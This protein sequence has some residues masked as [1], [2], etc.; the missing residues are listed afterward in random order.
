MTQPAFLATGQ[1][2][3]PLYQAV[4]AAPSLATPAALATLGFGLG[5]GALAY[6]AS[7][8]SYYSWAPLSQ[9]QPNGTTVVAGVGGNWL[10]TF[11]TPTAGQNAAS[12]VNGLNS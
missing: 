1:T 8:N 11:A 4:A 7:A 2:A 6:A 3:I 9:L 5:A 12:L 10:L